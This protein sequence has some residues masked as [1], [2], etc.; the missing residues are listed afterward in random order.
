M[1]ANIDF[2]GGVNEVAESEDQF[3]LL[4][5]EVKDPRRQAF[6]KLEHES[7]ITPSFE[8]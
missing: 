2:E 7:S 4:R 3:S 8:A 6:E 1:M 5:K